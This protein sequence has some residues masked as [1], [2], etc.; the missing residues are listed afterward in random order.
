MH[1]PAIWQAAAAPAAVPT[2]A[3]LMAADR[4]GGG[5]GIATASQSGEQRCHSQVA[6]RN[7]GY[8]EDEGR[9]QLSSSYRH[10]VMQCCLSWVSPDSAVEKA[11]VIHM[12]TQSIFSAGCAG[13]ALARVKHGT[14]L[15]LC[16]C[17]CRH[18]NARAGARAARGP[19]PRV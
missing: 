11:K 9:I 8:C 18:G 19:G 13:H 15:Q 5:G 10:A 17:L 16:N 1:C 3:Q 14:L 2:L 4:G 7:V 12:A 6:H